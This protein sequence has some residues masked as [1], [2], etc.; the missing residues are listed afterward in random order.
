MEELISLR[1]YQEQVS[2]DPMGSIPKLNYKK[3]VDLRWF[4]MSMS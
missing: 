2:R 4:A 1:K 3:K